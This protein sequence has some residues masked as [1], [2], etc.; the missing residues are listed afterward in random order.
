MSLNRLLISFTSFLLLTSASSAATF[1][2]AGDWLADEQ[3]TQGIPNGSLIMLIASTK[4]GEF[5]APSS[6]GYVRPDSDD[7]V[8]GTFTANDASGL[9]NRGSYT[10][11]IQANYG[12]ASNGLHEFDAGD[13]LL[14]RWFPTL[15]NDNLENV[16][17]GAVPYGEFRSD[18]VLA[19]SN[20]AWIAPD[21]NGATVNLTISAAA[22]GNRYNP[23]GVISIGQLLAGQLLKDAILGT[24][25]AQLEIASIAGGALSLSWPLLDGANPVGRL[26]QSGNLINWSEIPVKVDLSTEGVARASI[27]PDARG[28]VFYRIASE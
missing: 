22:V 11:T 14:I 13:P 21:S 27:Q 5:S 28:T 1:N 9:L 23:N 6:A 12:D 4:D 18:N 10:G 25:Q 26:Q 17:T 15:T 3:G 24:A 16:P 20:S 2:L 19:G 7:I 8:I